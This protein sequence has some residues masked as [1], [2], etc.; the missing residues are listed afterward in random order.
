LELDPNTIVALAGGTYSGS[1]GLPAGVTLWGA[2]PEQTTISLEPSNDRFRSALTADAGTA[3]VTNLSIDNPVGPALSARGVGTNVRVDRVSIVQATGAGIHAQSGSRVDLNDVRVAGVRPSDL[4]SS[5]VATPVHADDA[6]VFADHVFIIMTSTGTTHGALVSGA[7]SRLHL[8]DAWVGRSEV[9][10][11]AVEAPIVGIS[12]RNGGHLDA[13][14]VVIER[15]GDIGLAGNARSYPPELGSVLEDVVIL[16]TRGSSSGVLDVGPTGGT[17]VYLEGGLLTRA[18]RLRIDGASS[19]GLVVTHP[20]GDATLS[21][22]V[23]R[24][25]AREDATPAIQSA[26]ASRVRI[27]RLALDFDRGSGLHVA[28][29]SVLDLRKAWFEAGSTGDHGPLVDVKTTARFHG[30]ELFAA[31]SPMPAFRATGRRTRI[32]LDDLVLAQP[33]ASGGPHGAV[34]ASDFASVTL[35]GAWL[36]HLPGPAVRASTNAHPT[37]RNTF[38]TDAA[39]ADLEIGVFDLASGAEAVLESTHVEGVDGLGVAVRGSATELTVRDSTFRNV[40]RAYESASALNARDGRLIIRSVLIEEA[41]GIGVSVGKDASL[42][43]EAL[44]IRDMRPT[45]GLGT[46]G[47]GVHGRG[48]RSVDLRH[49]VVTRAREY[50]VFMNACESVALD[51]GIVE[52]TQGSALDDALGLGV[53]LRN[54]GRQ[55]TSERLSVSGSRGFGVLVEGGMLELRDLEVVETRDSDCELPCSEEIAHGLGVLGEAQLTL[56]SSRVAR[57]ETCGIVATEEARVSANGLLLELNSIAACGARDLVA[58]VSG[59]CTRLTDNGTDQWLD[60]EAIQPSRLVPR[61]LEEIEE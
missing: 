12:F 42:D 1:L 40:G 10:E 25:V 3:R 28:S 4:D 24:N 48:A 11:A 19:S 38:V 51:D 8:R 7:R 60:D 47:W 35:R 13:R 2:C 20:S 58:V 49:F 37:V 21:D 36:D 59:P 56:E 57:S 31:S 33:H 6:T 18:E 9:R 26:R 5:G 30:S 50:G 54:I 32:E 46:G 61:R 23:I 55:A 16:D 44:V 39:G 45:V 27:H 41:H 52:D 29:G 43:A 22:L 34:E 17:G 14:R 53:R 15:A